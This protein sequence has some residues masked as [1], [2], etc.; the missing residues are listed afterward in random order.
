MFLDKNGATLEFLQFG[1]S[2]KPTL[3]DYLKDGWQL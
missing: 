3:L 2:E 1:L